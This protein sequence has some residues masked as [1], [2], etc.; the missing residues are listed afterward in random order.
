MYIFPLDQCDVPKVRHPRLQRFREA[1]QSWLEVLNGEHVNS[2][3]NQVSTLFTYDCSYGTLSAVRALDPDRPINGM[4]NSFTHW[5]YVSLIATGIR[6]LVDWHEN[7]GSLMHLVQK[8]QK[9]DANEALITREN[10][11]CNDGLPYNYEGVMLDF[12]C[13]RPGTPDGFMRVPSSGPQAWMSSQ[14]AH[15]SFD[16]LAGLPKGNERSRADRVS[17]E[18]Y[19][20]LIGAMKSESIERLCAFVDTQIAHADNSID[21]DDP[22]LRASPADVEQALKAISQVRNFLS[23]V[24]L[25]QSFYAVAVPVPQYDIAEYLDVPFIAEDRLPNARKLWNANSEARN[26]WASA[27]EMDSFYPRLA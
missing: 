22:K 23:A 10:Y 8:I 12:H 2:I 17:G 6:R 5:G 16:R 14:L 25:N 20:R 24:V 9:C 27:P 11:V 15:Q 1:R 18:V 4:L 26:D 3:R 13:A 19:Q 21:V 7:T